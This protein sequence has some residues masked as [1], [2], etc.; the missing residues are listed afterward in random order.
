MSRRILIDNNLSHKLTDS[1]K[2]LGFEAIHVKAVGL[3]EASDNEI[4]QYATANNY[5]IL[6]K[7]SDFS[8]IVALRGFSPK[9]IQ[10]DIGNKST[11]A[12]A[13][14]LERNSA[15]IFKFLDDSETGLLV[16]M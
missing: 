12:I 7:D 15:T 9:V 4:W 3:Q 5:H 6:T 1:L 16:L 10:L 11:N 2:S 8:Y 13:E 14:L